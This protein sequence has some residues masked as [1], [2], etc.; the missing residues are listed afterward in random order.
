M[1]NPVTFIALGKCLM[2]KVNGLSDVNLVCVLQPPMR[3][4]EYLLTYKRSIAIK[5]LY[6]WSS[7][8]GQNSHKQGTINSV[9]S[10]YNI[11]YV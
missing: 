7:L 4:S 3:G 9:Q 10:L 6:T 1:Y 8:I 11:M 2:P 5:R